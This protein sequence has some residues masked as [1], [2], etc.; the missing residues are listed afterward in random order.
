MVASSVPT[1]VVLVVAE[2]DDGRERE[3]VSLLEPT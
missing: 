3:C 1:Q 2:L